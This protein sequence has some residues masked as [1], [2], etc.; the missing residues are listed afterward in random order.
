MIVAALV[1]ALAMAAPA[2]ATPQADAALR[3]LNDVRA[4]HRFTPLGRDARLTR[5]ALGH[6]ADMATHR[7]FDHV[8][9]SG[10]TLRSRVARTGWMRHRPVWKLAEN[11][12]WGTG[13][14]AA[15]RAVV[16]AWMASP[17]HWRNILAPE[18]RVVGIGVV[19]GTP[20]AGPGAT[21]TADFGT[22]R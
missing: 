16:A 1:A 12:A 20:F 2:P 15:P 8:S 11:I 5:A 9:P 13:P 4:A 6:S 19:L 14:L 22:R 21:Y 10:A 7:Y 17:G 18:L 3:A